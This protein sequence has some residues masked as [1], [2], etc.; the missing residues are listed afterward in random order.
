MKYLSN[1]VFA[2]W[3]PPYQEGKV[4]TLKGLELIFKKILNYTVELAVVIVFIFLIIG[5]FRY[6][7]SGGDPKATE[8]AKNTLTYAILG[9]VLLIG[10]WFILNFIKIFTG[11]DVTTFTIG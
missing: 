5:G 6:L 8:A 1:P 11:I 2:Q 4:A 3:G 7:T 9:I 10:I